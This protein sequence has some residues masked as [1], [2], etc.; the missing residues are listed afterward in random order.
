VDDGGRELGRENA[1]A[2][3]HQRAVLDHGHHFVRIDA[4]KRQKHEHLALRLQH[5][6]GRFPDR[7][8]PHLAELEELSLQPLRPRKHVA[9]FRPHPIFRVSRRHFSLI[10]LG[11]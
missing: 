9:G 6:G 3:D 2:G 8:V 10:R 1:G 4:W 7:P 11:R 5:V